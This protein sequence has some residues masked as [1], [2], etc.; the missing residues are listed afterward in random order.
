MHRADARWMPG[1][2]GSPWF[3]SSAG[4]DRT[5]PGNIAATPDQ[6]RDFDDRDGHESE[7][8]REQAISDRQG[9]DLKQ[10]LGGRHVVN[11]QLNGDRSHDDGN[12]A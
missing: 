9:A 8:Q 12:E 1:R 2:Y 4:P 10:P 7:K 5:C 11:G 3:M 6:L